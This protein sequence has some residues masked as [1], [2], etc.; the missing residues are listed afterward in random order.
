MA[1]GRNKRASVKRLRESRLALKRKIDIN[2]RAAMDGRASSQGGYV[3]ISIVL[4]LFVTAALLTL[5]AQ[6]QSERSRLERGEQIGYALSVLGAGLN[7]YLDTHY[8]ALTEDSPRVEHVTHPL[9]PTAEEIIDTLN[10]SGISSLPPTIEGASYRLDIS[11]PATCTPPQK[12]TEV[13]CRP[14]GLVYISKPVMRG[15]KVDYVALARATRVM[16]GQGGYSGPQDVSQFTF[17]DSSGPKARIRISNPTGLAGVLAWRSNGLPDADETLKTNGSNAMKATLRLNGDGAPHDVVGAHD[18]SASGTVSSEHLMVARDELIKGNSEIG[19]NAL[20]KKNET[21]QGWSQVLGSGLWTTHMHASGNADIRGNLTVGQEAV[22][23]GVTKT[24][25][26]HFSVRHDIGTSCPYQYSIGMSTG[27]DM[28]YC[29]YARKWDYLETKDQGSSNPVIESIYIR[30]GE[31][32]V[33]PRFVYC[34][35]DSGNVDVDYNGSRE[36]WIAKANGSGYGG[37]LKCFGRL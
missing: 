20:I 15:G 21:V 33:L 12:R 23:A 28:I 24:D 9:Q 30:P 37:Y 14:T 6:E 5:Y 4:V 22:I 19:G 36:R 34:R 16:R 32:R 29:G 35:T 17:P 7:V 10:I 31:T 27:G 8:T 26:L 13:D 3:M 18:I 1:H 11:F 2:R 25:N